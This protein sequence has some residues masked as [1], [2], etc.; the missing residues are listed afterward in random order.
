MPAW[1]TRAS[2]ARARG[3][4]VGRWY[5]ALAPKQATTQLA[6]IAPA[7]RALRQAGV[8]T[9]EQV[10][11][12]SAEQL[13]AMHGVGPIAISRLREALAEQGTT[14]AAE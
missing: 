8:T 12:C 7:T 13:A 14:F 6:K 5:T 9:L 10:A 4:H 3:R 2:Q 11:S 1:S